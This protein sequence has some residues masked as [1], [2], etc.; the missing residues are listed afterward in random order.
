MTASSLAARSPE[1]PQRIF[2]SLELHGLVH[3]ETRLIFYGPFR[4]SE[5]AYFSDSDA[6]V[7]ERASERADER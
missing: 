1:G 6:K 5:T 2:T 4:P 7:S 3:S